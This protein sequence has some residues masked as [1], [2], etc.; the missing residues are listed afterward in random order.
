M[1]GITIYQAIADIARGAADPNCRDCHGLGTRGTVKLAY[2]PNRVLI[3]PCAAAGFP[4][5]SRSP[6]IEIQPSDEEALAALAAH[7]P[8][9][10]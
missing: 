10:G 1:N 7:D 6:Y 9:L 5:L 4:R 2:R 3:C 8:P